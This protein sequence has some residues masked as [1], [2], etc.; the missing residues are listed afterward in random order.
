MLATLGVLAVAILAFVFYVGRNAGGS[1]G[2]TPTPTPSVSTKKAYSAPPPMT[3][4]TAHI[5]V[6][7]IT[8]NKGVI[9]LRLDPKLAPISVNNFVF[10]ARDHFYDG[11]KFHRVVAGFV[12][13]GGDPLGTGS[14]GPGYKFNDEPVKGEYTAGAVA[15]ANSGANTNGSQFFIVTADQTGKLPKSYNLFGYV[16]TGMDVVLKI[17]VGDVMSSV[18][19]QEQVS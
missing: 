13:Q 12:I 11:L 7:T 6:A 14:G 2:T 19:V 5:Y 17:A 15:M 4:N 10:L 3:I 1:A 18:T 16:Q 8:T 9:T